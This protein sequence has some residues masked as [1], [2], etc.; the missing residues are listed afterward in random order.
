MSKKLDIHNPKHHKAVSRFLL[1]FAEHYKSG[2]Q[3]YWLGQ[4]ARLCAQ[5]VGRLKGYDQREE[6]P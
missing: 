3:P 2:G 4:S 5:E 6:K 1:D